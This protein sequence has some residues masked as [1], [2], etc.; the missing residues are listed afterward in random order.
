MIT[1]ADSKAAADELAAAALTKRESEALVLLC[2][3]LP[4]DEMAACMGC[5][6]KTLDAHLAS[7]RRKLQLSTIE[8]V[9]LAVKAGW[10]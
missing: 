5:A 7:M 9:V 3:G 4:R 8:A 6:M 2:K 1:E 10:S